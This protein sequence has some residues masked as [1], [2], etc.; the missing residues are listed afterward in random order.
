MTDI[1]CASLII[2]VDISAAALL[3][4]NI[5]FK[6]LYMLYRLLLTIFF[7]SILLSQYEHHNHGNYS[8]GIITGTI[9]NT[10][11]GQP[12]ESAIITVFKSQDNSILTG[13]MANEGGYFRIEDLHPGILNITIKFIKTKAP[14]DN[15]TPKA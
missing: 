11:T 2:S 13:S 10:S 8:G 1:L 7:I 12:V 6:L 14:I 9:L 5:I 15:G 3:P 4:N